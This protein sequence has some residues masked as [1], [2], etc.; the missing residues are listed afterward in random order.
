[1]VLPGDGVG[2]W[3]G[4]AGAAQAVVADL[5]RRYGLDLW[6]VTSADDDR[7]VCVASAGPWRE[8]APPG[9]VWS[10]TG[11]FCV[12]T[13]GAGGAVAVPD[14]L[15]S[16]GWA[17]VAVGPLAPVRAYAG[18]PLLAA[19]GRLFGS[20]CALAGEPQPGSLADVL[21][22]LLLQ[23]RL[24][25]SLV[26]G[27]QSAQ[28]AAAAQALLERD[29]VTGLADPRG[30]EAVLLREEQRSRRYGHPVGVLTVE[31]HEGGAAGPAA[32]DARLLACADALRRTCRPGDGIA[33]LGPSSFGVVAV[34]CDLVCAHALATRLRVELRTVGV[35]AS[36]GCA[37]RRRDEVLGDT[38]RRARAAG[39]R[40]RRR[41][42]PLPRLPED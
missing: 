32:R 2:P 40:D 28:D 22:P 29:P 7:Q 8:L 25:S 13:V 38:E 30:W 4:L 42:T 37:C 41:R 6:M 36:V 18:V 9:S 26:A 14:V 21:P 16:P 1:M 17:E 20:V 19:D 23:A 27:E 10:W 24:L 5:H 15:A 3:P 33:R 12:R 11:S 39:E 35:A 34:E 31:V